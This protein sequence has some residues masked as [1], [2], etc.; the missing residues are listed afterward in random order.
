MTFRPISKG[1]LTKTPLNVPIL[2]DRIVLSRYKV[3]FLFKLRR[4]QSD[5]KT[6][7]YLICD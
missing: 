5:R 1:A 2:N 7:L 4:I 3:V 6:F